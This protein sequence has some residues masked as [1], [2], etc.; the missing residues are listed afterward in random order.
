MNF[1]TVAPGARAKVSLLDESCG[2]LPNTT[3]TVAK[4]LLKN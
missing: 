2:D 3:F 4:G 1:G